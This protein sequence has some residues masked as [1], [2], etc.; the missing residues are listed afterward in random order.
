[1]GLAM[2][3]TALVVVFFLGRKTKTTKR[4]YPVHDGSELEIKKPDKKNE[5]R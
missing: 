2:I 1:M 4:E 3:I 5:Q